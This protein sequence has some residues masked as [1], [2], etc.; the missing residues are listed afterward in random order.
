MTDNFFNNLTF[1]LANTFFWLIYLEFPH[2]LSIKPKLAQ[3]N[4]INKHLFN[5]VRIFR[6]EA[7]SALMMQQRINSEVGKFKC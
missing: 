2:V 1:E 4:C 7:I 5:V 6:E 3:R